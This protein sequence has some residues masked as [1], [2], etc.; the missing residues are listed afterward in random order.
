MA[1]I[2]AL[3][4][5]SR[6]DEYLKNEHGC[7]MILRLWGSIPAV[8]YFFYLKALISVLSLEAVLSSSKTGR[9]AFFPRATFPIRHFEA[10]S[11][12]YFSKN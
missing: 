2:Y 9:R 8:P 3:S 5:F 6:I 11:R 4:L 10:L 12:S 1:F 7:L